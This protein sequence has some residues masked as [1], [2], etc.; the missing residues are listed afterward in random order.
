MK[1][2]GTILLETEYKTSTDFLDRNDA[3]KSGIQQVFNEYE[4]DN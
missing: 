4:L 3:V 1:E 2:T